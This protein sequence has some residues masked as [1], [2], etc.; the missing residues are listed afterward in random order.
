MVERFLL[1]RRY[2]CDCYKPGSRAQNITLLSPLKALDILIM[3]LPVIM[4]W[5]FL[6]MFEVTLKLQQA[7]TVRRRLLGLRELS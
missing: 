5:L 6:C 4:K 2:F 7:M 1:G 3:K